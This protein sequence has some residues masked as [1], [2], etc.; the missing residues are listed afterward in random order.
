MNE[1]K[2]KLKLPAE[3]VVH[4]PTLSDMDL[5]KCF[6]IAAK[7]GMR[8]IESTIAKMI[9]EEIVKG[10]KKRIEALVQKKLTEHGEE[11]IQEVISRLKE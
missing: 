5:E 8:L 11:I 2:I 10:S 7:D 6:E 9:A 4:I 1:T 3:V